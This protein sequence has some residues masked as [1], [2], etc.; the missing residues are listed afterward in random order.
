MNGDQLRR[1]VAAGELDPLDAAA[2]L[3]NPYCPVEVAEQIADSSALLDL[4]GVRELLS[5][6]RGM[7][8]SRAMSLMATLPWVSLLNLARRPSTPPQVRRQAERKILERTPRMA[9]GEKIA[10][11]RRCHR[12]LIRPL[13]VDAEARV[14]EALLDNGRLVENDVL[15][16]LNTRSPPPELCRAVAGHR[17]WG[18]CYRIRRALVESP[19]TPLPVALSVLVQ[20]RLSDLAALARKPG[21]PAPVRAAS[22]ALKEKKE[23]GLEGMVRSPGDHARRPVR[24]PPEDLR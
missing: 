13:I 22:A 9:L 5:G 4:H 12:P 7:P 21:V 16:M 10:L 17:R 15:L 3:R 24:E 8:L 6:F 14:L 19:A 18:A 11:A 23:R 1:L 20:L 2:V